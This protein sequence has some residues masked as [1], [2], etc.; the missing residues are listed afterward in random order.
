M[1]NDELI[2]MKKLCE[3]IYRKIRKSHKQNI[4]R[5]ATSKYT[6]LVSNEQ[7]LKDLKNKIGNNEQF[8][9]KISDT[10][11]IGLESDAVTGFFYMPANNDTNKENNIYR[12]A[13]Y[14]IEV[15]SFYR[16]NLED[17][18][19][20]KNIKLENINKYNYEKRKVLK[21]INKLYNNLP[22]R[23]NIFYK[24]IYKNNGIQNQV[25]FNLQGNIL[26]DYNYDN[27]LTNLIP[28]NPEDSSNFQHFYLNGIEMVLLS[29]ITSI[30]GVN[31]LLNTQTSIV[32]L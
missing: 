25:N 21:E 9:K 29:G 15:H 18:L 8:Y 4:K 1:T 26:P 5:I 11:D 3:F 30:E 20:E 13:V 23:V 31:A 16:R 10:R 17:I 2:E 7:V 14:A 22:A 6:N 24:A 19:K 28:I 32:N 27:D 12:E